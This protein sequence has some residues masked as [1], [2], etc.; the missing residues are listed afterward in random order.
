L[1]F[2]FVIHTGKFLVEFLQLLLF[3]VKLCCLFNLQHQDSY[4]GTTSQNEVMFHETHRLRTYLKF[5]LF[6]P[7]DPIRLA[8][9]G[10]FFTRF[11]DRVKCFRLVICFFLDIIFIDKFDWIN[12]YFCEL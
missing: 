7:V 10:F 4:A 11:K 6:S 2:S 9:S 3:A 8:H 5:P 1:T 12:W